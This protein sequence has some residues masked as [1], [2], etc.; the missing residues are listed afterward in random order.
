MQSG[1]PRK[2][3]V[4][5]LLIGFTVVL[6]WWFDLSFNPFGLP[7][8]EHA[9]ANYTEPLARKVIEHV[10]LVLCPGSLLQVFSIGIGGW[11]S[12]GMWI[13]AALLNGPLY[14]VVG[15]LLARVFLN[16]HSGD[17]GPRQSTI[18]AQK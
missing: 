15:F 14:Y 17:H 12:W 10:L 8:W 3:A 4:V 9:P 1:L 5:G 6:L 2:F 16:G 11:V 13:L 7:T 18:G